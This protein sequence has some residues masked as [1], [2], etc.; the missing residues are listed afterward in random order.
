MMSKMTKRILIMAIRAYQRSL[1]PETGLV[2]RA[3]GLSKSTCAFFP[4]CSSY[5]IEAI[6]RK[7][8]L[9]GALAALRRIARCHPWQKPQVD[10]V[11]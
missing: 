7:G 11:Q 8:P 3:L 6:E 10:I 2:P 1:S 9:A 4:S 5:A